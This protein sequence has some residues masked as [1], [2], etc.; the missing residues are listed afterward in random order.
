MAQ[1]DSQ[2]VADAF[3][4]GV[5]PSHLLHRAQ[6]YAAVQS[7]SALQNAGI[8]LR[9]F[10]VLAAV[11]EKE[12]ASQ[13]RLVDETGIDRSTLADMVSRMERAGHIRR[14]ASKEDARA[15]AVF[16]TAKGKKALSTAAPAVKDADEQLLAAL[17]K[18]RRNAFLAILATFSDNADR[19]ILNLEADEFGVKQKSKPSKKAKVVKAKSKPTKAKKDDKK[20]KKAKKKS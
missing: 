8:T 7:A 2:T 11:A 14:A 19:T 3:T 10:S 4:L 1:N 17:P 15:K 9:Q 20:K 18:N 12:G 6:Q 13:S 5:S 16:L